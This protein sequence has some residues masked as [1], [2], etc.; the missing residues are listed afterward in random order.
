MAASYANDGKMTL[1]R[2]IDTTEA[3]E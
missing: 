1:L 3:A 2:L